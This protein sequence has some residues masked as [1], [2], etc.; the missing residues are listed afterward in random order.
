M[1]PTNVSRFEASAYLSLVTGTLSI[2]FNPERAATVAR[3]GLTSGL[4][5]VA[6]GVGIASLAITLVARRRQNWARW[7]LSG[8]IVVGMPSFLSGLGPIYRSSPPAAVLEALSAIFALVS[9]CF[10]FTGDA[11]DWFKRPVKI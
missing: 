9:V 3:H 1:K 4:V 5:G 10:I 2:P 6:V 8:M 7:A 11:A